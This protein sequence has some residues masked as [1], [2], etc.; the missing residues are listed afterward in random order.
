MSL[1]Y[2]EKLSYIEDVGQV[3]MT[4][5]FDMPQVLQ[6]K[7]LGSRHMIPSLGHFGLAILESPQ[8]SQ[9]VL[10]LIFGDIEVEACHLD[11]GNPIPWFHFSF[12]P[13]FT[14]RFFGAYG[15]FMFKIRRF[16]QFQFLDNVQNLYFS[17]SLGRRNRTSCGIA[18]SYPWE[19]F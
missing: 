13:G 6:E 11:N 16:T 3:G 19:I 12:A 7:E 15:S 2:A 14:T 17:T 5:H 18:P 10:S 1:G 4:E 9:H 8:Y